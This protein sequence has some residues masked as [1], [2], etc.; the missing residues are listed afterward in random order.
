MPPLF[1]L[2]PPTPLLAAGALLTSVYLY[3][4]LCSTCGLS[5]CVPRVARGHTENFPSRYA[6]FFCAAAH[7]RATPI[8]S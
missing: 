2:L 4:P 3:M 6:A 1:D 5:A 8:T 7:S